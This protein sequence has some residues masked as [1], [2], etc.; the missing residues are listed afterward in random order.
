MSQYYFFF[1][2]YNCWSRRGKWI[3]CSPTENWCQ[4]QHFN[5]GPLGGE[6]AWPWN[7]SI[8]PWQ[9]LKWY[10]IF[11]LLNELTDLSAQR[12]CTAVW[13]QCLLCTLEGMTKVTVVWMSTSEAVFEHW[14]LSLTYT[15][16]WT[17]NVYS[18]CSL[19]LGNER[20]AIHVMLLFLA[21]P[22]L[23]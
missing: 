20:R 8:F 19:M 21:L 6:C 9:L 23:H 12:S 10:V 4:K 14:V 13:V 7:I 2:R 16:K 11:S 18:H 3:A 5:L 15:L 1:H 17:Q 22:C